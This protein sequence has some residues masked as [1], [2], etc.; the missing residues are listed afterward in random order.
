MRKPDPTLAK[1][2]LFLVGHLDSNKQWFVA[3]PPDPAQMRS[4]DTASQ[5]G[6]ALLGMVFLI[7]ALVRRRRPPGCG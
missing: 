1:R 5:I 6:P 7:S 2:R 3:P 4:L